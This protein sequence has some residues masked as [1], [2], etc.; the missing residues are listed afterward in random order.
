MK[1]FGTEPLR[2]GIEDPARLRRSLMGTAHIHR[3]AVLAVGIAFR[4][5]G[6]LD[7]AEELDSAG[8]VGMGHEAEL[9]GIIDCAL[10]EL[11][12]A[13]RVDA[14]VARILAV[15]AHVERILFRGGDKVERVLDTQAVD[16]EQESRHRQIAARER[17]AQHH[18]AYPQLEQVFGHQASVDGK[19]RGLRGR[20]AACR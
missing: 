20:T 4:T 19:A 14:L 3:L 12:Q 15:P 2:E 9:T 6:R 7:V 5:S 16:I 10:N 17:A 13:A 18:V 11:A 8:I 1:S